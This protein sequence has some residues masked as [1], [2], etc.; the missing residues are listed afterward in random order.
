M[1]TTTIP[2]TNLPIF[3]SRYTIVPLFGSDVH[4]LFSTVSANPSNIPR[5]RV[6]SFVSQLSLPYVEKDTI[7]LLYDFSCVQDEGYRA[8]FEG[9][10]YGTLSFGKQ[11][12]NATRYVRYTFDTYEK[13]LTLFLT[14]PDGLCGCLDTTNRILLWFDLTINDQSSLQ[15]F[16]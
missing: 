8:S 15:P 10:V 2:D 7:T 11:V 13:T 1:T 16:F 9:H 6:W 4:V 3:F 14:I 12:Y 5:S